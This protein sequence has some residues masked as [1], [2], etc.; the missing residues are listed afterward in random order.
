MTD[1][2]AGLEID[3]TDLR[4]G[5]RG[6]VVRVHAPYQDLMTTA[7]FA[8]QSA[9]EPSDES[10]INSDTLVT[11]RNPRRCSI[12]CRGF[13][14]RRSGG[15]TP[16]PRRC[17][18]TTEVFNE[19]HGMAMSTRDI[20]PS[21][22][23]VAVRIKAVIAGLCGRW[24]WF[25]DLCR[26]LSGC[27]RLRHDVRSRRRIAHAGDGTHGLCSFTRSPID[28]TLCRA[29]SWIDQT[30]RLRPRK[31]GIGTGQQLAGR[32]LAVAPVFMNRA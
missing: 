25:G 7:R 4:C 23:M 32:Y 30:R 18:R 29:T 5:L 12:G 15:G 14:L 27:S 17:P 6:A 26:R 31:A 28:Q 3:A 2:P 20:N 9:I 22:V 1:I 13:E 24:T 11:C 21:T 10:Q 16:A 19:V 8:L